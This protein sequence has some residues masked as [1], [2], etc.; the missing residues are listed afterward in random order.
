MLCSCPADRLM[1]CCSLAPTVCPALHI[2][3]STST[4]LVG[5]WPCRCIAARLHSLSAFA[6]YIVCYTHTIVF[7]FLA[8]GL[9]HALLLTCIHYLLGLSVRLHAASLQPCSL[10]LGKW[11]AAYLFLLPGIQL[12]VQHCWRVVACRSSSIRIAPHTIWAWP[13]V[14]PSLLGLN[15]LQASTLGL[16]YLR[17]HSCIVFT[18]CFGVAFF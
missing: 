17:G 18:G 9:I 13:I 16:W 1:H 6:S 3:D 2:A 15:Q 14:M 10:W 4:T 5:L 12:N 7:V 8:S 11:F